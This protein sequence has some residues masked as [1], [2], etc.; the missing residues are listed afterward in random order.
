[1][2]QDCNVHC[3]CTHKPSMAANTWV[4]A[5]KSQPLTVTGT[6]Q[7]HGSAQSS[8]KGKPNL[9]DPAMQR[10]CVTQRQTINPSGRLS[11]Q[12]QSLVKPADTNPHARDG[13]AGVCQACT[14][15]WSTWCAVQVLPA[16]HVQQPRVPATYTRHQHVEHMCAIN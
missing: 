16:T 5:L 6:Q 15:C 4:R 8:A 13:N 14:R 12:A 3:P 11:C 7:R 9:G 1:M 10:P 2:P